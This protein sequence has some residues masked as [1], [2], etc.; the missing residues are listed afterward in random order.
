MAALKD[1]DAPLNTRHK[2]AKE[3]NE[4]RNSAMSSSRSGGSGV[5]FGRRKTEKS[6][7][8][9]KNK[10]VEGEEYGDAFRFPHYSVFFDIS[11]RRG[12]NDN[13]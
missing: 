7:T 10:L 1:T 2:I 13:R 4:N 3:V 8:P 5:D 12:D 9:E 11:C 6:K